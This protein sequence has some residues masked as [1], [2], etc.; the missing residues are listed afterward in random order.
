I[1]CFQARDGIRDFHVTGVQTCALPILRLAESYG[2]TD[3]GA[4]DEAVQET[5]AGAA[6]AESAP[7]ATSGAAPAGGPKAPAAEAP[8]AQATEIGRASRRGRV[9]ASQ[10][11]VTYKTAQP[12]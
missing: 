3:S 7:Q 12:W 5:A 10:R 8:T 9:G 4:A 1:S 2:V 11:A 6:D